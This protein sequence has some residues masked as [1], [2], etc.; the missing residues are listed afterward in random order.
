MFYYTPKPFYRPARKTWYTQASSDRPICLGMG[1]GMGMGM[2]A[3]FSPYHQRL[4]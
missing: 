3:T 4:L 1:M 2:D